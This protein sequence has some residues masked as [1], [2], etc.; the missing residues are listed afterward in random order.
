M[1]NTYGIATSDGEYIDV[2]NTERGAKRYATLNDY[3]AVYIRFNNGYITALV[4][5]R[6]AGK[7]IKGDN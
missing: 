5:T 2:S 3:D 7:W 1:N 4:S 6:I